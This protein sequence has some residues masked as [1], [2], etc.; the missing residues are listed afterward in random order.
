MIAMSTVSTICVGTWTALLVNMFE[1][2]SQLCEKY[3]VQYAVCFDHP[4]S[5]FDT[6]DISVMGQKSHQDSTRQHVCD[7]STRRLTSWFD[8]HVSEL[9]VL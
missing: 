4:R 3:Q 6:P 2:R 8:S 9:D 1:A 5:A 7:T